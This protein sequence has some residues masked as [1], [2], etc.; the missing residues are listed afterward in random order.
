MNCPVC[1]NEMEKGVLAVHGQRF[2]TGKWIHYDQL[3]PSFMKK[4]AEVSAFKCPDC[5]KV[6]LQAETKS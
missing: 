4:G 3:L 2:I 5:G 1:K 6:E